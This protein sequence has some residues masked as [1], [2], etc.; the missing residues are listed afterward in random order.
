[1]ASLVDSHFRDGKNKR[2]ESD[3]IDAIPL[4]ILLLLILV[5]G[6]LARFLLDFHSSPSYQISLVRLLSLYFRRQILMEARSKIDECAR[7]LG[8]ARNRRSNGWYRSK[9]LPPGWNG[10][11]FVSIVCPYLFI[12]RHRHS[13]MN[14]VA[15]PHWIDRE[16]TTWRNIKS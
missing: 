10:V 11:L 7:W 14:C 12:H 9:F 5:C 4:Y 6:R 3:E 15:V 1:M 8:K 13:N 16:S 2:D